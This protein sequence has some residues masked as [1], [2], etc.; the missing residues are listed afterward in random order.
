MLSLSVKKSSLKSQKNSP[1]WSKIMS[2]TNNSTGAPFT[3]E[4]L[5]LFKMALKLY[6]PNGVIIFNKGGHP[7]MFNSS[8]NE[9]FDYTKEEFESI[10]FTRLFFW[11]MMDFRVEG[12]KKEI[13]ENQGQ[14]IK[15]R[16]IGL[17]KGD[18]TFIST[19]SIMS[20]GSNDQGDYFYLASLK[21][22]DVRLR[23]Q[24]K[25]LEEKTA[26]EATIQILSTKI[27]EITSELNNK[28]M[29][30]GVVKKRSEI[31]S[32]IVS[33][34]NSVWDSE[35]L[36]SGFLDI[37]SIMD[38][39]YISSVYLYDSQTDL[40]KLSVHNGFREV[41]ADSVPGNTG[42]FGQVKK[43]KRTV[44]FQ[45]NKTETSYDIDT[46]LGVWKPQEI[47]SFPIKYRKEFL[48]IFT[49]ALSHLAHEDEVVFYE[50][51]VTQLGIG[52]KNLSQY[53]TLKDLNKK[54]HLQTSE[55]EGQ[56]LLL[57][58]SLQMKSV[59]LANVSHEFMTPLNAIIGFSEVMSNNILGKLN[60]KQHEVVE[61]IHSSG[62]HLL[63]LVND[64]IV[65]SKVESDSIDIDF[66]F[67]NYQNSIKGE[68]N[69]WKERALRRKVKLIINNP[70]ES[71]FLKADE[72]KLKQVVRSLL[73]NAL[74]F[75]PEEDEI[76]FTTKV[77]NHKLII[78]VRDGGKGIDEKDHKLIFEL[79]QQARFSGKLPSGG[80]GLGLSLSKKYVELHDGTIEVESRLGKG[81]C[82]RVS[83]PQVVIDPKNDGDLFC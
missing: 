11:E 82:F 31:Y 50:D 35:I 34:I 40:F 81:A 46:P 32:R 18:S 17:R 37:F 71:I 48:G 42:L 41:P 76:F 15:K 29:E 5:K 12:L 20:F 19:L 13:I 47:I 57:A 3:K 25:A 80:S 64:L 70:V 54:L 56:N 62:R 68:L 69:M 30:V 21:D 36:F 63:T 1:L 66:G 8:A 74:K 4:S 2:Q 16:V 38:L 10:I 24:Q 53:E 75:S 72:M 59:F 27:D 65:L 45:I 6:E 44:R 14:V 60:E 28:T 79:F 55:I 58:K 26:G 67:F 49:I 7:V 43:F 77:D 61:D 51:L 33:Y 78:E 39:S 23:I 73:S 9:M 83:L 52:Y 22:L